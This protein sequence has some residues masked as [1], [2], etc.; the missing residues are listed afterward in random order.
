M[1]LKFLFQLENYMPQTDAGVDI[2]IT[3][4]PRKNINNEQH[5]N[6]EFTSENKAFDAPRYKNENE[7]IYI[8]KQ[9]ETDT[10][11]QH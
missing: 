6:G 3:V 4:P 7:S 11:N 9:K 10:G 8:D 1:L 2:K 5:E